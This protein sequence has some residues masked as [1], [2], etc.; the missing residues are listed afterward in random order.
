MYCNCIKCIYLESFFFIL[1][2]LICVY[3]VYTTILIYKGHSMSLHTNPQKLPCDTSSICRI[4][5]LFVP[6]DQ[7]STP[8]TFSAHT[9]TACAHLAHTTFLHSL[10]HLH[11]TSIYKQ[12]TRQFQLPL[13]FQ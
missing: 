2:D 4:F 8:L 1:N 3:T 7:H 5:I 13:Q 9:V 6:Y 10:L 11:P 12:D